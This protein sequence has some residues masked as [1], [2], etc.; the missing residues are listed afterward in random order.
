MVPGR[1]GHVSAS[2]R[3]RFLGRFRLI[4]LA[5]VLALLALSA[6]AL[7]SPMGA[8]PDDDYH[9]VSI[10]CSTGDSDLCQPGESP[11]TRMV[12]QTVLQSPCYAFFSDESAACQSR[13]DYD[14]DKLVE[15]NRGNFVGAYPPLYYSVMSNFV[16]EDILAS[17]MAMRLFNV[18]LFVAIT[19]ALYL[20][21]PT[22]RRPALVWGWLISTVPLGMFLLASNN[23]SGWAVAGVGTA[24]LAL[25]GYFETPTSAKR[26]ALGGLFVVAV[27]MA[28]GSRGDSALYVVGGIGV[29]AIIAFE[30]SRRFWSLA[31]LPVLMIVVSAAFFLTSRQTA[32]G[33]SGFSSQ[34]TVVA[35][36]EQAAGAAANLAGFGLLAYNF[37][38]VPSLWAGAFGGWALGWLD[39]PIPESVT[40]LA[41]AAFIGVG[42]VGLSVLNGRK[43][44]VIAGVGFVLW[45]LPTYVL[46]QGGDKVGEQVQPRYILP[47]IVLLGGLLVLQAGRKRFAL[48]RTQT[49]AV[50]I[51]LS[52][53]N[54]VALHMN[55]RRYVTGNDVPGWNLDAGAEWFWSGAP[56]PMVVWG[57]GSLAFAGLVAILAREMSIAAARATEI[58]TDRKVMLPASR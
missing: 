53:A 42:F 36:T 18:A 44:I 38:N 40:F 13:L 8:A 35:G 37:L 45:A 43:A 12:P 33:I 57:I 24:W 23:P 3:T 28:A 22:G 14:S 51:A 55:M 58:E 46:T 30:N 1:S 50:V 21:L 2:A 4:Y 47:L 27:F 56:A 34:D 29:A 11:K 17:V 9:L 41:L 6:W 19:A 10:W 5:P 20:L 32:S 16:G 31:V 54:L 26:I 15:T 39:T 25:L 7:A 52:A 49:I 48:G